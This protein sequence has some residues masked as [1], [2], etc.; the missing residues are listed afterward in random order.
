[1]IEKNPNNWHEFKAVITEIRETYG[2]HEY[3]IGNDKTYKGKNTVLFRGQQCAN[4]PLQT[5]LERKTNKEYT[6]FHYL[7]QPL[8]R[9]REL[10]A[11]TGLKWDIEDL[12][13]LREEMRKK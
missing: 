11:Y 7:A 4:W 13:N 1:M 2:Y 3:S 6:V 8:R 12:S 5:T 10:E 9:A